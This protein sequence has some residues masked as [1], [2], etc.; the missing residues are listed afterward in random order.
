MKLKTLVAVVA[1]AATGTANAAITTT[2][3]TNGG[4]LFVSII[5]PGAVAAED[6]SFHLNLNML[7]SSFDGNTA[8]SW[9]LVALSGGLYSQFAGETDLRFT[10]AGG[11]N[12]NN[13]FGPT[14]GNYV[15]ASSVPNSVLTLGNVQSFNQYIDIQANLLDTA[16][17]GGDYAIVN[18]G[19]QGFYSGTG[20]TT[21]GDTVFGVNMSATIG[22]LLDFYFILPTG[23][24]ET[25]VTQY[26]GQW[27]LSDAGVLSYSAVPVPAA[28][29]LFGSG[30]VGL[31]SI[32]RRRKA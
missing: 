4:D 12:D 2:D 20:T 10:V 7:A 8:Y 32:A 9:D 21:W 1:L 17:A 14:Y 5:N 6:Q 11:N 22:D 19:D 23:L 27:S 25:Q 13:N 24:T 29:W 31:I 3:S 26:A 15:T 16:A 30:L 28:V 18:R